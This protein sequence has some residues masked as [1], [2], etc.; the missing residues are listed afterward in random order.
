[1]AGFEYFN[2][3]SRLVADNS[4]WLDTAPDKALENIDCISAPFLP[5]SNHNQESTQRLI[6]P[7]RVALS[8]AMT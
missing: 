4:M 8:A 6:Q 2:A 1:M 5:T 3:A 7:R